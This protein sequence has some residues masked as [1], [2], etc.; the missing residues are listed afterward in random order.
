MRKFKS[1][2]KFEKAYRK[3]VSRSRF[4]Q[5]KID[6]TLQQME[7]DIFAPSLETHKLSGNLSGLFACSC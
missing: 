4:L 2:P 6:K 3:F 5:K 7:S 1:T